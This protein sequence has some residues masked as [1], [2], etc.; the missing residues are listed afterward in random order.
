MSEFIQEE[1][2]FEFEQKK[3]IK[4]YPELHWTGKRPYK[5]TVYYPAQLKEVYGTEKNGWLN[6]IF[7]G[8]NLQVMSHLLKEFRGKIDLVYID[9]PFDSK[10]DYKKRIKLKGVE[11]SNNLNTFEEKQY[12]DIWTNDEYLQFMY[13]R[14]ILLKELMSDKAMIWVQCDPSRG[15]YIKIILDE[16][17]GSNNFI[18]H[19]TWKR[20]FAH[21]D[22]GQGAQHLG[23]I[24]DFVLVYRKTEAAKLN[25]VFT[26]YEQ[27]YIDKTFSYTDPDG[28]RWQSVSLTA[29]GGAAK[30]N[31]SYEFL[32]VVRYWQYSKE[33]MQKLLDEGKIYQPK[34]GMVPRKKMYLDEAK[35][36]PLQDIW[37]DI[38]PVQ[39]GSLQNE[40][41]PTQKPED[42]L[43]RI[44]E[45]SSNPGDLIFDC[46]MGSGT[47]QAVAMKLGRRFI[48]ADINLGAIQTTTKRLLNTANELNSQI[49]S[50][51]AYTGL[52]VYNV[53]NYDMFRNPLEAKELILQALEVQPFESSNIYDGEKDGRMVKIMP[54]NRIATKADL[55]S[56][57]ANL[58]YK[59]FEKKKEEDP[60]AVVLRLTL[61]CMG[62]E[63]DLAAALTQE[64][65]AYKVDIEV[66][67]ILH[68]RA[69][70]Q[71]KRDAEASVVIEN[72]D[73]VIKNFYPLNLMQKLSLDKETVDEW[74]QLV[75]SI[76]I[77]F[78]YDGAIMQPTIIDIPEKNG[79]VVGRYRI[80]KD[81]GRIRIKI[82]DVLAE[83]LE[84]EVQNG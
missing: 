81:A 42:L 11:V 50:A 8:D 45:V 13:E 38:V 25:A 60:N 46:F 77:D 41:Y 57:I 49:L 51:D 2:T 48:G 54:V 74:R 12:S 14:L 19:V 30:G 56:L 5:S 6:K 16:I 28:R 69:D 40:N 43:Q 27:S 3:T 53:N 52:E 67:D 61:V 10:A 34:P 15:H 4:G 75:E 80:P 7:W 33:N 47:T 65:N 71:F 32:G 84:I 59:S 18:N 37:T 35:G 82:T 70:L 63:S 29:P 79:L 83:S 64:L 36:I 72:G 21:G 17:F 9:P 44:I 31:P 20:T 76:M 1:I 68:D 55:Q 39:G 24:S 78:N 73:L 22:I 58:P 66:V 23:R 26:P 62:H